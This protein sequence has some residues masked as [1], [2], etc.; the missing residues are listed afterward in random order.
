MTQL[1]EQQW[2]EGGISF[3]SF[4]A[5]SVRSITR[6]ISSGLFFLFFSIFLTSQI[7]PSGKM[8]RKTKLKLPCHSSAAIFAFVILK[9]FALRKGKSRKKLAMFHRRVQRAGF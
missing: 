6:M 7:V 5:E 9:V 8:G 1:V 3:A 4:H 2:R